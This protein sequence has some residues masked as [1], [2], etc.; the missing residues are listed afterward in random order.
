[1]KIPGPIDHTVPLSRRKIIG[2]FCVE[3]VDVVLEP[4]SIVRPPDDALLHSNS[5]GAANRN[6]GNGCE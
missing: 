3:S 5:H 1:M 4:A 6:H 2:L